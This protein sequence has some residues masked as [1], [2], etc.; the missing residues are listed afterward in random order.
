MNSDKIIKIRDL[1]KEVESMTGRVYKKRIEIEIRASEL[2]D[3][4]F[5]KVLSKIYKK[6]NN[7]DDVSLFNSIPSIISFEA[8]QCN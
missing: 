1:L 4:A 2:N 7:H 5:E 3:E 6:I 8:N